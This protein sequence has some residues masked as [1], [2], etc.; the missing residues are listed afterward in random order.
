MCPVGALTGTLPTLFIDP[1]SWKP[2]DWFWIKM[3]V[4]GFFLIG[5][6][7][8]SRVWCRVLCPLGAL[9]APTNKLSLISIKF[10]PHKCV[11]CSKC[12]DVCPMRIDLPAATRDPECIGCGMCIDACKKGALYYAVG[13]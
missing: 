12:K 3:I 5:I 10:D 8:I 4:T 11:H 9:L 1:S 2:G 6:L 7:A 13:K